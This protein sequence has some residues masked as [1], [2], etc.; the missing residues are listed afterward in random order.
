MA[1]FAASRGWVPATS[2]NFS[3]RL[4]DGSVAITV[5]GRD[6]GAIGKAD[7]TRLTPAGKSMDAAE[8]S[9]ET[10]LHLALYAR[11][12]DIGAVAHTHS[13]MATLLSLE[14]KPALELTGLELLKAFTAIHSHEAAVTLPVFD[15]DQDIAG[16]A[17]RVDAHMDDHGTGVAYLIRGHGLYTWGESAT[18]VCR[19]LD[20]LEFLFDVYWRRLSRA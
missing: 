1:G 17:A 20:A 13:P 2:G 15:N 11:D 16:L 8:P 18:A 14:A 5:S 3:L 12:R 6:K 7:V 9:A 19:H 10:A 4:D